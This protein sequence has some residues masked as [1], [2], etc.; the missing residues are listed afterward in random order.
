MPF[1]ALS[2]ATLWGL[3]YADT[4]LISYSLLI[5]T[6]LA[7]M[8]WSMSLQYQQPI[9]LVVFSNLIMLASWGLISIHNMPGIF[10]AISVL[11]IALYL[12]ESFTLKDLYPKG[13]FALRSQL[14][15]VAVLSLLTTQIA[16]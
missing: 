6:F 12:V 14:T 8:L 9:W 10:Y 5:V 16:S 3:P 13:F 4:L 15:F 7:G 11:F 1:I 2:S